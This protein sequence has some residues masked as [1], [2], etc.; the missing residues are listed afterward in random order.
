V[1]NQVVGLPP[2][3]TTPK[4][5][6]V[7]A[8]VTTTAASATVAETDATTVSTD[9]DDE[10]ENENESDFVPKRF[11]RKTDHRNIVKRLDV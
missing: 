9:D 1:Y 10:G 3:Q 11:Q 7:V 8:N 2:P 6:P 5:V 4:A